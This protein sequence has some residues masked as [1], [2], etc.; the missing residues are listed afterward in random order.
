MLLKEFIHFDNK[1]LE[2]QEDNRY[3]SQNDSDILRRTDLRKSRITLG[4]INQIRK[5]SEAHEKDRQTE[6]AL[7]RKMYAAPAP[8]AAVA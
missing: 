2:P 4:M 8:E 1:S 5:A 6:L 7:I 3:I